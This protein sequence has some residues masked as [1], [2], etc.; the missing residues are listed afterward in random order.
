MGLVRVPRGQAT[1]DLHAA[2]TTR[3]KSPI[4]SLGSCMAQPSRMA[5]TPPSTTLH[6]PPPP[7]LHPIHTVSL[8]CSDP[9]TAADSP[10][11]P[12]TL[13]HILLPSHTLCFPPPK[14]APFSHSL[15]STGNQGFGTS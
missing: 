2:I 12:M 15:W 1:E 9:A 14:F 13:A 8:Y 3:D 7:Y 4:G 6:Q 11:P 10:P 5:L